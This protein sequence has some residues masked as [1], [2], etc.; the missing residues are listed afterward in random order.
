MP[1]F[2]QET[3]LKAVLYITES[4]EPLPRSSTWLKGDEIIAHEFLRSDTL[5]D[6]DETDTSWKSFSAQLTEVLNFVA[7]SQKV[8]R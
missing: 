2:I 7:K 4:D 8:S 1:K 5:D 3:D 6:D